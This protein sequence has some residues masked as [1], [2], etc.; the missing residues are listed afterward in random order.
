MCHVVWSPFSRCLE[1]CLPSAPFSSFIFAF[2]TFKKIKHSTLLPLRSALQHVRRWHVCSPFFNN[3]R[4]RCKDKSTFKSQLLK[5][6]TVFS[7]AGESPQIE[8]ELWC[9]REWCVLQA[10]PSPLFQRWLLP[11]RIICFF[12]FHVCQCLTFE[13]N[14]HCVTRRC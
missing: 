9:D 12:L 7:P 14:Q 2:P 11:L 10:V 1:S 4:G 3:L 8:P 13:T 5:K 6:K